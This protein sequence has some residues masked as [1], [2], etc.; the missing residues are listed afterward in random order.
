MQ[1][2]GAAVVGVKL[3]ESGLGADN[4]LLGDGADGGNVLQ[5]LGRP[6]GP[7]GLAA[8]GA[9]AL[10]AGLPRRLLLRPALPARFG[11]HVRG[12][13]VLQAA[14]ATHRVHRQTHALGRV[15]AQRGVR[16]QDVAVEVPLVDEEVGHLAPA[17]GAR[18]QRGLGLLLRVRHRVLAPPLLHLVPQFLQL[19]AAGGGGRRAAL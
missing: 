6:G 11:D 8:L 17:R 1:L 16:A 12:N 3:H 18:T 2:N 13:V 9:N 14:Q 7:I 5:L 15:V 4:V 19:G 10:Q